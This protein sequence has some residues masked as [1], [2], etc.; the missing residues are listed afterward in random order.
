MKQHFT[1][2]G[3]IVDA[4]RT[5]LLWHRRLQMWVPPGGHVEPNED[6]VTAV[7]REIREETGLE[8]EVLPLSDTFSFV[9]PGQIA[10]PYTILLEDIADPG[11]PHRHIDMI[12]FCRPANSATLHPPEGA[13]VMWVEERDLAADRP[14]DLAACGVSAPVGDDVRQLALVAI[15][16]AKTAGG[17]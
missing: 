14:V 7:L 8:A 5:L 17:S 2:T 15:H 1:C 9:Y 16:L 13:V 3:F 4:D 12:Y 6:P 11:D 10:P